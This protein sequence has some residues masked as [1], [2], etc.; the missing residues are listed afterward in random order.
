M[1]KYNNLFLIKRHV[2]RICD[3]IGGFY[4]NHSS[5]DVSS[6]RSRLTNLKLMNQ[7]DN[8]SVYSRTSRC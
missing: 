6:A 4:T 1:N 2:V 7:R 8:L 3:D 5:E